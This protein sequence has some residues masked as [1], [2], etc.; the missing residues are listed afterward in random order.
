MERAQFY[1]IAGNRL[2]TP[3]YGLPSCCDRLIDVW[4]ANGDGDSVFAESLEIPVR[5]ALVAICG[6]G[7]LVWR[8]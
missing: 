3:G 1:S 7:A 6:L 5:A 4:L 8:I 2:Q